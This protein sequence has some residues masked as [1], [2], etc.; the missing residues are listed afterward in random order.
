MRDLP[1]LNEVAKAI[2]EKNGVQIQ[3][4][5]VHAANLVG[6]SEQV[7]GRMVFLTEGPSRKVKIGS[8]EVINQLLK[9][10]NNIKEKR[11]KNNYQGT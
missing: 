11:F 2:E 3:P 1:Y 8:Q 6:L 5:R 7:L 9:Q 4:A 10:V